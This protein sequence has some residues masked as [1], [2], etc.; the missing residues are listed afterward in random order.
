[1][2]S[3]CRMLAICL[4][5]GSFSAAHGGSLAENKVQKEQME[6]FQQYVNGVEEKCGVKVK[7]TIDFS[8][9]KGT[10]RISISGFCGYGLEQIASVCGD[11]EGKKAVAAKLKSYT[12]VYN[13]K[14]RDV[15]MTGGTLKYT[16]DQNGTQDDFVKKYLMDHL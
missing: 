3:L 11:E 5:V 12:C 8:T 7:A 13:E 15:A 14:K 10:E 4:V 9:F 2:T 16:V 1:M 6:S